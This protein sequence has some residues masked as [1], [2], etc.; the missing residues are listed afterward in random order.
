MTGAPQHQPLRCEVKLVAA[1]TDRA[2]VL[3]QLRLLPGLLRPLYPSRTVQNVYLDTHEDLALEENLAGIS[4]RHKLRLRW[5]GESSELVHGQLEWKRRENGFGDKELF[6]LA[7]AVTFEG[8]TRTAFWR[9]LHDQAP[10]HWQQRLRGREPA[11]WIRYRRDYLAGRS[12][13]LRITV[14]SDLR[15]SD[16]RFC[17]TLS[18]RHATPLPALLIVEIKAPRSAQPAIERWLQHVDLQPGKCSKFVLASR[19]GGLPLGQRYE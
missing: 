17:F 8:A 15:A 19:P 13:D 1:D 3:A 18:R 16:Q 9:A 2:R 4:Q 7:S 6:A 11:Q 10:P 5:Y 14:D 12:S